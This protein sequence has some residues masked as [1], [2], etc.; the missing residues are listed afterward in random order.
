MQ[1]M[2]CDAMRT[3]NRLDRTDFPCQPPSDMWHPGIQIGTLSIHSWTVQRSSTYV[4]RCCAM[5]DG[6][7][8]SSRFS[9]I[10]PSHSVP[11]SFHFSLLFSFQ[12]RAPLGWRLRDWIGRGGRKKS[13]EAKRA[14]QHFIP[15][16]LMNIGD[17]SVNFLCLL[18]LV[19]FVC[20]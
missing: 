12:R 17:Y 8:T 14:Q 15:R 9:L 16:L 7:M 20:R 18:L 3:R 5:P 19:Y 13:E 10:C 11:L 6:R 1:T 4:C 2:R